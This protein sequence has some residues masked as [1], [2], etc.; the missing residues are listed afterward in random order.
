LCKT[1][2]SKVYCAKPPSIDNW[3]T[4]SAGPGMGWSYAITKKGTSVELWIDRG[5][6][7]KNET[8]A[9]FDKIFGDKEKIESV[10]GE[11]IIWDKVEGRR[12][13][14]I[15][16]I[17]KIGG[18]KD[19]ELWGKIQDDLVDRMIRLEKVLKPSLNKIF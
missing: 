15:K 2:I 7:K 1:T 18:L 9:W 6:D 8:D 11:P 19:T 5:P 14:R 4:A 10:F 17:S 3:I 12:V 16:S 13:C